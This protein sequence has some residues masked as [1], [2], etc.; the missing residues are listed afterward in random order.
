MDFTFQS[1]D[2]IGNALA[3]RAANYT[4]LGSTA[5]GRGAAQV[6]QGNYEAAISDFKRA[7][8]YD[9]TLVAAYRNLGRVYQM[10]GRGDE[11][12]AAYERGIA[13]DRS[14]DVT[15]Q[16]LASYYMTN[17]RYAEAEEQLQVIVRNNPNAAGPVASLG[18]I[19][20]TQGRYAEADQKFERV[21]QLMPRDAAAHY[22]MGV[23]RARQ[24][25]LGEAI[26]Q[27]TLATELRPKYAA[28]M[29]DLAYAYFDNGE[30][31]K[32]SELLQALWDLGT[33]ESQVLA[34]TVSEYMATPKILFPDYLHSTFNTL[35]GPG[36]SLSTLDPS[37]ATP[38]ASATFTMTF[39]F[40]GD[41]DPNS[42]QDIWNWNISKAAGGEPGVYNHGANLHPENE[43]YI[44]PYPLAVSYDPVK[45]TA[46]L[47]FRVSQNATGNA[48]MDPSHW[49]FRFDG[50]DVSGRSMDP[51]YDQ[52][53]HGARGPF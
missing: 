50:T 10:L 12:V 18:H 16:D 3:A 43:A 40:N 11:A 5:L 17:G 13:A 22:S 15:R 30:K 34:A 37:L 42:V 45:Q 23:L 52:Y 41:M 20:M 26:D 39:Q 38:G 2:S 32:A 28:A 1:V 8:A 48:V 53:A 49:V 6:Q 7:V 4:A 44:M 51:D 47:Y 21:L 27:L 9:P 36:T 19:Y 46:T 25:E 24:G 14:S 35:L 31:D 33:D 29:A